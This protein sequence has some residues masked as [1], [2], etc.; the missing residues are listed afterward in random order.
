LK[1]ESVSEP[2][3][4]PLFLGG[5]PATCDRRTG[6]RVNAYK[7]TTSWKS[8]AASTALAH[9][10][11][12]SIEEILFDTLAAFKIFTSQVAMHLNVEGRD[13]LF[14]QLDLLLDPEE[15]PRE[16][17]PPELAS[18]RTLLRALLVL[19]PGKMPGLGAS[20]RGRLVAAWSTRDDR[21][22]IQCLPNDRLRWSLSVRD[23]SERR[24]A[25]AESSL[26]HLIPELAPYAPERWFS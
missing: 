9:R 23:G 13:K 15:W 17:V 26:R 4:E 8:G 12:K 3:V 7:L 18:Y 22:T 20:S 25:A 2:G 10:S 5:T 14:N 19:T 1:N 16:D 6:A 21:L 11:K 24:A